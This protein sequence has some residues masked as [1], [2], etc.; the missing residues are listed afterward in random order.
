M[1]SMQQALL[2]LEDGR[3]FHGEAFGYLKNT[4]GEVCFNTSI[5]GYQEILSDPSYCG[6]IV[7]MTYPEIGNCGINALDAESDKL[8]VRGLI[9]EELSPTISNWR[10]ETSLQDYLMQHHIPGICGIDTRALTRHLRIHGTMKGCLTSDSHDENEAVLQA[11]R[12][13]EE[14]NLVQEVTTTIPY[15]WD[16][17][18]TLSRLWPQMY[19]RRKLDNHPCRDDFFSLPE[20]KH[21]I[22]AYD[23]GIKR[24]ILRSLRQVGFHVH[25]V[26]A[27][28]PAEE[29]LALQP[30]GIVLSNGPGDPAALVY[31][32]ENVR[33]LTKHVPIFGICL[34]HQ[35]LGLAFGGS[36]FKLKFGH[37][38][39]NQP[40]KD[41]RTGQV[42]ITSQNHG[43]T[44]APDS[45]PDSLE[46]T[47]IN[48]NDHTIAGLRH[49]EYPIFSVQY[50]PEA[51]PGPHESSSLF[52]KFLNLIEGH[53]WES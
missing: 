21:C 45:L 7:A 17:D 20:V 9:I 28:T 46:I 43:F 26:P 32:R 19:P 10:A 41:L 8:H 15:D 39:A 31:A 35:I 27:S 34:G 3:M 48:L 49:R 6:Q 23:F 25:V 30:R 33:K 51:S 1:A 44:I 40:V 42:F 11:K 12:C 22:V 47:Q 24:N 52:Q 38:G 2:A 29:A 37:R 14:V 36:T 5:T 53:T 50:H 13:A 4:I 18:G 16:P